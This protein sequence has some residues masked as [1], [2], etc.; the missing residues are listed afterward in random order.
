MQ[1]MAT[2]QTLMVFLFLLLAGQMV[3]PVASSAAAIT[4]T[5]YFGKPP[6]CTGRGFC[7][8]TVGWNR[9]ASSSD[10]SAERTSRP[11]NIAEG[12]AVMKGNKLYV[13]FKSP[14]PERVDSLPV[15]EN[16]VLESATAR[17]FAAKGVT[18]LK[19]DYKVEYSKNKFGSI[20]LN[21][22]TRN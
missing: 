21:L 10:A 19:G 8:I 1:K 14:M 7:K 9:L 20:V 15:V 5:I 17:A 3:L 4:V 6:D 16:I 13:D 18:V 12:S 22:E 11:L 2:P